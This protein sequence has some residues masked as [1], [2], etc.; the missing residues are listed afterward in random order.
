VKNTTFIVL[1][2]L[3][4][5]LALGG[6]HLYTNHILSPEVAVPEEEEVEEIEKVERIE[7]E[8]PPCERE[9]KMEEYMEVDPPASMPVVEDGLL[10]WGEVLA[11]AEE[12]Q[13]LDKMVE[14]EAVSS[15]G[16]IEDHISG[17][18]D[19]VFWL[20]AGT[21]IINT[22]RDTGGTIV[23]YYDTLSHDRLV[24]L[25]KYAEPVI[26]V[27]C[28]NIIKVL[29]EVV[30]VEKEVVKEVEKEVVVPRDPDPVV[31]R[32]PDPEPKPEKDPDPGP[33]DEP[34]VERPEKDPDPGPGDEPPV[35]RPE[36]DPDPGPGDE[37]S[38]ERPD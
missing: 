26:L 5:S 20:E 23:A 27:T 31:P 19:S 8:P 38:V 9:K 15:K 35:E 28:G 30:V 11:A 4:F 6:T 21:E 2:I 7:L 25:N 14:L 17:E 33:G 18:Y 13:F 22:Y 12:T 1:A 3:I 34:P 32:D 37:P 29:P 10:G 16:E 36:K 24:L